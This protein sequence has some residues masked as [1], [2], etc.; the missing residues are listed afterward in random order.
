MFL[1]YQKSKGLWNL[2]MNC[3]MDYIISIC[4]IRRRSINKDIIIIQKRWIVIFDCP[5]SLNTVSKSILRPSLRPSFY[6]KSTIDILWE[7]NSSFVSR[8]YW[9]FMSIIKYSLT[10]RIIWITELDLTSSFGYCTD[11]NIYNL[12]RFLRIDDS[13]R[14]DIIRLYYINKNFQS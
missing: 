11:M 12:S 7:I 8:V 10:Y 14:Q 1:K 4:T 3:P 13:I 5:D 2:I 9:L 6:S